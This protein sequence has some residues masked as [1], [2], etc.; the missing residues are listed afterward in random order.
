GAVRLFLCDPIFLFM[1][2]GYERCLVI[3]PRLGSRVRV[4][5]PAPV[6]LSKYACERTPVS[7]PGPCAPSD[8]ARPHVVP[9]LR[10]G[11]TLAE[12]RSGPRRALQTFSLLRCPADDERVP[13]YLERG[14]P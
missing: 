5:F 6:S 13:P 4:S 12:A 10:R 7:C 11:S 14:A 2:T 9:R 3:L 1:A 8:P